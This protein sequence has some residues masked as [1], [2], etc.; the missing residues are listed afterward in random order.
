VTTPAQPEPSMEEILASIRRIISDDPA[1]AASPES[2]AAPTA[3]AAP[4][5]VAAPAMAPAL[6]PADDVMELTPEMRV[7]APPPEPAYTPPPEPAYTPSVQTYTEPEPM[8]AMNYSADPV[9]PSEPLMSPRTEAMAA[10]A[11][12]NLTG[13]LSSTT[14]VENNSLEAIV[15]EMLRP[16]LRDWMDRNLPTLVERLVE[17]EIERLARRRG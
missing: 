12:G 17:Q 7:D 10:A 15:R 16:M 3:P 2:A 4:E 5:P 13:L 8:P 11:L 6:T 1:T 14:K 9:A